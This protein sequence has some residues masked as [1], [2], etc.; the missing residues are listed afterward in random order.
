MSLRSLGWTDDFTK[1]REKVEP[2]FGNLETLA[3]NYPDVYAHQVLSHGWMEYSILRGVHDSVEERVEAERGFYDPSIPEH[4]FYYLAYEKE[5]YTKW[6][7]ENKL[8]EKLLEK[9]WQEYLE[10]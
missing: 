1:F 9:G 8:S 2:F 10:D 4:E 7:R 5:E 3:K 6:A